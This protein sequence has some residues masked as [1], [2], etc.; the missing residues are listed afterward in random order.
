MA[1]MTNSTVATPA[2]STSDLMASVTLRLVV[3][4]AGAVAVEFVMPA[5]LPQ[6]V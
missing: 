5:M 3:L 4:R 6:A 1:D 2:R